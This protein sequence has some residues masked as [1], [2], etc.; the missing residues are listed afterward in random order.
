[1]VL[2]IDH[3]DVGALAH[4]A[5]AAEPIPGLPGVPRAEIETRPRLSQLTFAGEKKV[6]RLPPRTAIVAFSAEEVYGIAELIRRQRG[7]A[8]EPLL[9]DFEAGAVSAFS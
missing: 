2:P 3:G 6:S 1:M 9:G 5:R 7:G 4:D 8:G